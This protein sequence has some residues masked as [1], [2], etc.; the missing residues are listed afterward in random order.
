MRWVR[1]AANPKSGSPGAHCVSARL[2]FR[3]ATAGLTKGAWLIPT[4][5]RGFTSGGGDGEGGG[6]FIATRR[7]FST[8]FVIV[9]KARLSWGFFVPLAA[10]FGG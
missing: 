4:P 7:L 9:S 3:V 6:S 10:G 8:A 2:Q 5:A 1:A